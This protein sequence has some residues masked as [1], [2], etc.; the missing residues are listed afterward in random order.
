MSVL[1]TN[2]A[3]L[4]KFHYDLTDARFF[5]HVENQWHVVFRPYTGMF[6]AN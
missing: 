2:F 5:L 3:A 1:L 4:Y 6:D